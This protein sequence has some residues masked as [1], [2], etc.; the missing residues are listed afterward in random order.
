MSFTMADANMMAKEVMVA[1]RG[2]ELLDC[3][4][5]RT[6]SLIAKM[7]FFAYHLGREHAL[8]EKKEPNQ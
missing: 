5:Q 2:G 1:A 6:E 8:L 7:V 3:T 4:P